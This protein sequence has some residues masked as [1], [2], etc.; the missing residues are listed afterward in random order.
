MNN[1]QK[2]TFHSLGNFSSNTQQLS[3]KINPALVLAG[4]GLKKSPSG[5]N[6]ANHPYLYKGL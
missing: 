3:R 1:H 5:Q 2:S 4:Q 6:V